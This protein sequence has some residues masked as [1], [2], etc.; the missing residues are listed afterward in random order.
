MEGIMIE[1]ISAEELNVGKEDIGLTL[2]ISEEE[3]MLLRE[4]IKNNF[5]KLLVAAVYPKDDPKFFRYK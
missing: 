3:K 1:A 4:Y 5:S 2:K